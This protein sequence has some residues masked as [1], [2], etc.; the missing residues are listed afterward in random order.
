[1][2]IKNQENN[3]SREF[4]NFT[5]EGEGSEKVVRYLDNIEGISCVEWD[6]EVKIYSFGYNKN[7]WS[8]EGIKDLYKEAKKATK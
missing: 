5:I 6:E 8:W 7:N 3:Y 2:R 4:G 1:M